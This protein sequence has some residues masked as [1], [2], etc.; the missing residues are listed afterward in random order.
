MSN[1]ASAA[2]KGRTRPTVLHRND[3]RRPLAI[4]PSQPEA[5]GNGKT[6]KS[7]LSVAG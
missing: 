2:P 6:G 5:R 4:R 7:T 3:R 1:T